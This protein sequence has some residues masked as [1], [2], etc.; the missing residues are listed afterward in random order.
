[1]AERKSSRSARPRGRAGG[2][3]P[4]THPAPSTRPVRRPTP[5]QKPRR[6]SALPSLPAESPQPK[7]GEVL[8]QL[9]ETRSIFACAA[10]CLDEITD[11]HRL[12]ATE[13]CEPEDVA[14]VVRLG[15]QRLDEVRV[16]LDLGTVKDVR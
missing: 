16:A 12:E 9:N 4:R 10:R 14:V 7:R 3:R 11:P 13:T 2:N 6:R 5:A 8:N 15:I 1:M